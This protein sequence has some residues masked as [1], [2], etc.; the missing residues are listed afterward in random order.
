M[1]HQKLD[2]AEPRFRI[3][4]KTFTTVYRS[5]TSPS[6]AWRFHQARKFY[7][8][9]RD[10]II[11]ALRDTPYSGLI[12]ML[13]G[14]APTFS[15]KKRTVW[16]IMVEYPLHSLNRRTQSGY[17]K[18]MFH[19]FRVSGSAIAGKRQPF[20][21]K[22][23]E[24]K[25]VRPEILHHMQEI[26]RPGDIILT[27]HHDALSNLFLPGFWPHAAFHLGTPE[28]R[29]T[30]GLPDQ[31]NSNRPVLEAKKDG[32]K[33]RSLSETLSVDAFVVLRP[34]IPTEELATVITRALTHEGKLYDFLFDF[35]RS[36]RLACTEVIYRAF[37]GT[38][39]WQ[40]QLV[41]QSGRLTLPAGDLIRQILHQ[42]HAHVFCI[43]GAL[44]CPLTFGKKAGEILENSL[45]R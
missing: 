18:V 2:E 21:R 33:L 25:M 7:L 42:G 6:T 45:K 12:Q 15:S 31:G 17:H 43:F 40:L 32:V 26:L 38:G 9:N 8:K 27:R 16:N 34:D 11:G 20:A 23:H 44:E 1:V 10:T 41:K 28:A 4:R 3:P 36:E 35:K 5:A 19:L 37:H 24:G 30:L 22:Q 39:T 13:E 29:R 14:E